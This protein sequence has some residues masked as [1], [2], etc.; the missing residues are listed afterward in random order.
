MR[1][2]VHT[3]VASLGL[4]P[5]TRAR[6][7]SSLASGCACA[8]LLSATIPSCALLRGLLCRRWTPA[9][10]GSRH[11]LR[12]LQWPVGGP[13]RGPPRRRPHRLPW[14]CPCVARERASILRKV[15]VRIAVVRRAV[16][17]RMPGQ[18]VQMCGVAHSVNCSVVRRS[19]SVLIGRWSNISAPGAYATVGR[20]SPCT[21]A[22]RRRWA[23]L[24]KWPDV[25]A[26]RKL[27]QEVQA[28]SG[29][30]R[31]CSPSR[32]RS[33]SGAGAGSSPDACTCLAT[34]T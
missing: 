22:C 11:H 4:T 5:S 24:S 30:L 14:K 31:T 2:A 21:G 32:A 3:P 23:C 18:Y 8:H 20:G 12:L 9:A 16:D 27:R 7:S 13:H 28:G 17:R 29:T 33:S 1:D 26:R 25:C 15:R 19:S 10:P 34:L 6:P